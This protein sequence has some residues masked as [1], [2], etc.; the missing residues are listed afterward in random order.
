MSSNSSHTR[1]QLLAALADAVRA[2]QRA[3]DVVDEL[4]GQLH[5]VNRTDGRCLDILEQHGRISAGALARESG[6]TTGA[7]TAVVDRLQQAG[8]VRRVADPEDR[9]RVLVELT[10]EAR[11]VAWELMGEP[12][13]R[14]AKPLLAR[15]DDEQLALLVD[16]QRRSRELQERHAQWLRERL[17]AREQNQTGAQAPA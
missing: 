12:L 2:N 1:S 15:Y 17:S 4:A 9:R 14:A 8:Y 11:A 6:L 16:F 3:T 10:P 7:I 13:A 5:G